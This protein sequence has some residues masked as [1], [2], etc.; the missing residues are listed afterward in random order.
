[1]QLDLAGTTALVTGSYRGT[2]AII[3]RQLLDEGMQVWVHGLEPGQAE[4]AVA[5]LGGGDPVT[6]DIRTEAGTDELLA[7]LGGACPDVLVNNYGAAESGSWTGSGT[8]D[9]IAAYQLNVLSAARLI[10]HFLPAMSAPDADRR[11]NPRIINLGTV[12][13]T[14]PNARNPHYYA[15]KGA[16]ATMTVSLAREVSGTGIRVNL[17]SPGLILTPEVQAAYLKTGARKGWGTTWEE[18]ERH[19]AQDIPIGRIVTREEVAA[20]VAFLASPLADGIHG[21]NIRVDGGAL[22]ILT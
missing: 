13:S 20:L 8:D 9:W 10:A 18:V 4:A 17:I 7:A 1:M 19:V 6:G 14:R 22:G 5:E 15:A 12:G 21:Q 2:G 11:I 3:A 16:L